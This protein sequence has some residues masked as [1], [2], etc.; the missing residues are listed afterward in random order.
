MPDP[1]VDLFTSYINKQNKKKRKPPYERYGPGLHTTGRTPKPQ[2]YD[3][4]RMA[5][6]QKNLQIAKA[7]RQVSQKPFPLPEW[8]GGEEVSTPARQPMSTQVPPGFQAK[9]GQRG[10]FAPQFSSVMA[11]PAVA[12]QQYINT[13][14]DYKDRMQE[15][16]NTVY[17][18]QKDTRTGEYLQ[19]TNLPNPN[20]ETLDMYPGALG[21]DYY[22]N[23][24]YGDGWE[25][26]KSKFW[27]RIKYP[28]GKPR[29]ELGLDDIPLAQRYRYQGTGF[30]NLGRITQT[31]A[32]T[33][34][35]AM[36]APA[37][38]TERTYGVPLAVAGFGEPGYTVRGKETAPMS[39]GEQR[40]ILLEGAKISPL[41][42]P[43]PQRYR[44]QAVDLGKVWRN[45]I[46][47]ATTFWEQN[48]YRSPTVR[49]ELPFA[50]G[51]HQFR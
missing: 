15:W 30:G 49:E 21:W 28:Y 2:V 25:G 1:V 45:Y 22:G 20:G 27:N 32:G 36:G 3:A 24:Y 31:G 9:G 51:K 46:A 41:Q 44:T 38:Y 42:L 35:A 50:W 8:V 13:F 34:I 4:E 47:N 43:Y 40:D 23:A 18:Q 14:P 6:I 37:E 16:Q 10:A 19:G 5:E 11:D 48:M 7:R 33:A 26:F 12:Q 39:M 29:E 17:L